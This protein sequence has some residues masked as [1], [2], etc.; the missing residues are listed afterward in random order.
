MP[1]RRITWL[2]LIAPLGVL[3]LLLVACGP[4]QTQNLASLPQDIQP[5]TPRTASAT[6]TPE[7]E[8]A[9]EAETAE[10]PPDEIEP[11]APRQ[12]VERF[13]SWYVGYIRNAGDP[14][15]DRAYRSSEYIT[16]EFIRG[17]DEA[18][19]APG[20]GAYDPFLHAQEAPEEITVAEA[21]V[22]GES[23][24]VAVHE[25]WNPGTRHEL[26]QNLEATLQLTDDEWQIAGIA[27]RM[28][29]E[30]VVEAFYW[31][32][33]GYPGDPASDGI[34]RSSPYVSAAFVQ[35]ADALIASGENGGYDPLLC[36]QDVPGQISVE[37]TI[38]SSEEASVLVR[39]SFEDHTFAVQLRPI[40]GRWVIG[41]VVCA[42][43]WGG[44]ETSTTGW[45][46]FEDE[47]Y[48]FQIRYPDGWTYNEESP[49]PPGAE[50]SDELKALKRVLR[51]APEGWEDETPPLYVEVVQGT[52]EAFDEIFPPS[53]SSERVDVN[54]FEAIKTIDDLGESALVRYAFQNPSDEDVHVVILD[55]IGGTPERARDHDDVVQ[56]VQQMIRTFE[57]SQ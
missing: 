6:P 57:F 21:L 48:G 7:E 41:D 15:T 31:W 16:Q 50:L 13:Y 54:G 49:I 17:V 47:R 39:T 46:V 10:S 20:R 22:S 1:I 26:I 12:V 52:Q 30:E 24:T 44:E 25:S 42:W 43:I 14:I 37:E 11:L 32:Y 2:T 18:V 36:A 8:E 33:T 19:S 23:A 56:A 40:E 38:A 29:P 53:A 35:R 28:S 9:G 45:Q 55:T 3:I 34:Y 27:V 5:A 51:F 4:V